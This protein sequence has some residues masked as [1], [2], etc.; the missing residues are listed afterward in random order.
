MDGEADLT[1]EHTEGTEGDESD[2]KEQTTKHTG[3][4]KE[5]KG[6][7]KRGLGIGLVEPMSSL[8]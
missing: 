3:D 7:S 6:K 2:Q 8:D 5:Q 1:T 4:T